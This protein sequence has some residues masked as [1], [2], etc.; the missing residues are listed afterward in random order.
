MSKFVR[1][2][3]VG[4]VLAGGAALLLLLA[5]CSPAA[6][7]ATATLAAATTLPTSA[8]TNGL[9]TGTPAVAA[10]P[11][12]TSAATSAAT[13]L[14]TSEATSMATSESTSAA[15]AAVTPNATAAST[16]TA[17]APILIKSDKLLGMSVN[18]SSGNALGT[19]SDVLVTTT[20]TVQA[21]VLNMS[22]ASVTSA[23]A[24]PAATSAAVTPA[25]GTEMAGN[26]VAIPWTS[27]M[28]DTTSKQLVY[29]GAASELASMPPFDESMV[30]SGYVVRAQGSSLP[31]TYDGLI[32]LGGNLSD[33]N[34]ENTSNVKLGDVQHVILDLHTGMAT[35]AVVDFGGF[36]GLGQTSV[37]VPWTKLSLDNT[38]ATSTTPVMRLNVTKDSLQSAPKFDDSAL[39]FWPT[40][41]NPGWDSQIQLFWQTAAS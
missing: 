2:V 32:R 16:E 28:A 20:G 40:P 23:A 27:I 30:S 15:T 36:L 24:T 38:D 22:A 39:S 13:S 17:N 35:Y 19:I 11:V 33:I 41:A 18:D 7:T 12:G 9:P 37:M 6:S 21:V 25:T 26:M 3:K 8:A 14:A 10:S 4:Q 31:A 5:A 29:Q 1:S 34:L